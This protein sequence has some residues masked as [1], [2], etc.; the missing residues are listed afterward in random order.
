MCYHAQLPQ[1][2]L[3]RLYEKEV[4]ST[5]SCWSLQY[6]I[7]TAQGW[8]FVCL[9]EITGLDH[10]SQPLKSISKLLVVNRAE[11]ADK[12]LLPELPGQSY[13]ADVSSQSCIRKR[14][15]NYSHIMCPAANWN[16]RVSAF[17]KEP[18]AEGGGLK[19]LVQLHFPFQPASDS[20]QGLLKWRAPGVILHIPICPR[21]FTFLPSTGS[22]VFW[23]FRDCP[24]SLF[25]FSPLYRSAHWKT[26]SRLREAWQSHPLDLET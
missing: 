26:T 1:D 9:L 16:E 17:M 7:S 14:F 19:F 2:N 6:C 15:N 18:R 25:T 5:F 3:W 22:V 21:H 4:G 12:W 13:L 11:T 24:Y 20:A 23:D 10:A 8:A